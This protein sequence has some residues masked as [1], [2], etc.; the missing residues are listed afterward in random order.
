MALIVT[1]LPSGALSSFSLKESHVQNTN[2]SKGIRVPSATGQETCCY[3]QRERVTRGPYFGGAYQKSFICRAP[4]VGWLGRIPFPDDQV[5]TKLVSTT[6]PDP[7]PKKF[8]E[9]VW[10]LTPRFEQLGR[11]VNLC[12]PLAFGPP[13]CLLCQETLS[14][15]W[16][17]WFGI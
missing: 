16:D 2:N 15:C 12:K 3:R 9:T 11:H 13:S 4:L 1:E 8:V 7:D 17:L 10:R 6:D 14:W 5:W